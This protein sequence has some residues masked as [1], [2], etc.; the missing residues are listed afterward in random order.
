M[1]LRNLSFS[2]ISCLVLLSACGTSKK[3]QALKPAPNYN[4]AV[5]YEKQVSYFNLPIEVA[6]SDLQNQTNK[7][8]NGLIFEDNSLDG[9]NIMLRVWKQAPIIIEEKNGK[10]E[11]TLPLK[12]WAKIRYGVEKFGFSVYDTR[13]INLNGKA[14]ISSSVSF[15]NWKLGTNT[16]ILGIEWTETPSMSIA[17]KNI[18]LTF[19]LDPALNLF[20]PH[21]TRMIDGAI[22]QSLDIKP[23]ILQALEQVSK[24][25]EVNPQYGVWFALQPVELYSSPAIIANKKLSISLGMKAYLETSI[26]SKPT[27]KFDKQQLKLSATN[28]MDDDFNVSVAGMITYEQAAKLI[29]KNFIGQEFKSGK[30][31]VSITKVDLW[32]KDGRLIVEVGMKG[33]VNG[34]FYLGGI[35]TYNAE[36]KE[37]YLDQVDFVLDSKNKLHKFGDWLIHGLIAKKIQQNC[38]F[39]ISEQLNESTNILKGYLNAYEPVKGVSVN[40]SL[41]S[42]NPDKIV[43]TPDAIIAIMTAKGQ[44]SLRINGLQ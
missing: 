41:K 37:I 19:L 36:K 35:P 17:G 34:S 31:S 44:A 28:K 20:K 11:F 5:V 3:I 43:L 42:F 15:S 21:L 2:L 29:Q 33:S 9:D 30:R 25:I 38:K 4:T 8:F 24:P 13:E 32:G 23:Y 22:A 1:S 12:I 16:Q 39:P 14:K 26:N 18:P 27:L 40:G 10:L 6:V 7:Y